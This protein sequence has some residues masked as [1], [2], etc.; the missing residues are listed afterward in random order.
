MVELIDDHDVEVAGVEVGRSGPVEALDRGEDVLE[1]LWRL[2]IH[3]ELAEGVVPQRVAERG[4][5]WVRISLRCA[6][7]RRRAL[8]RFAARRA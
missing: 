7:K 8:G 1:T 4:E 3:P 6:T 2:A 5:L